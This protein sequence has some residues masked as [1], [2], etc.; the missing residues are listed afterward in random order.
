VID[1]G[2]SIAVVARS[3]K[4]PCRSFEYLR[5]SYAAAQTL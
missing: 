1:G 4:T 3:L 5:V 2:R